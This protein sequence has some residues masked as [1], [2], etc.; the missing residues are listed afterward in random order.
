M[1]LQNAAPFFF[2]PRHNF[3]IILFQ[4]AGLT[5]GVCTMQYDLEIFGFDSR[6]DCVGG[7]GTG[8][9][10]KY[11]AFSPRTIK[12]ML[13]RMGAVSFKRCKVERGNAHCRYP[14]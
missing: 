8:L 13:A 3:A 10:T 14:S 5:N 2:L 9:H 6:G 4:S 11:R 1:G 12:K 7:Y